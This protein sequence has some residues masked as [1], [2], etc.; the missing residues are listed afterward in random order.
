MGESPPYIQLQNRGGVGQWS[1]TLGRMLSPTGKPPEPQKDGLYPMVEVAS[2]DLQ[3]PVQL[4][5]RTW[6]RED[7]KKA[8][9]GIVP[10]AEDAGRFCV[11]MESVRHSYHL[12]E[13]E[14]E[15][16]YR[17]ALG[18][19]WHKVRP[20]WNPLAQ[21]GTVLP[22]GSQELRG[23]VEQLQGRIRDR[24]RQMMDPRAL[25]KIRQGEEEL[26]GDFRV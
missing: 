20:G 19:D 7:V 26:W 10:H 2:G 11:D 8:V 13:T 17:V 9:E 22:Q 18:K 1:T 3:Q 24:Y 6:T 4:V 12:N 15:E 25:S 5:S 16:A 23:M 14:V 21:D